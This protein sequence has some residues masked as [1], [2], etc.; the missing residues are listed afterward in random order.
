MSKLPP[1]PQGFTLEGAQEPA[2]GSLPPIPPGFTLEQAEQAPPPSAPSAPIEAG[3]GRAVGLAATGFNRMLGN[4][5]AFPFEAAA[6]FNEMTG[7]NDA[8]EAA[9]GYKANRKPILTS[10]QAQ[11]F[12]NNTFGA[13]DPQNFPER[14]IAAGGAGLGS[15]VIG[16]PALAALGAPAVAPVAA[17]AGGFSGGV[18]GQAGA[19]GGEAI[20]GP[21]GRVIGGL[22]GNIAGGAIVPSTLGGGTAT[23]RTGAALARPLTQS[24][25][26]AIVGQVLNRAAGAGRTTLA[27]EPVQGINAT[28]G[29]RTGNRGVLALE[30]MQAQS[31]PEASGRFHENLSNAQ[32]LIRNTLERLRGTGAPARPRDVAEQQIGQA[33]AA[34]A[35][36][37]HALQSGRT[38]TQASDLAR[39]RIEATRQAFRE[40]ETQLWQAVGADGE[41]A[42]VPVDPLRTRLRAYLSSQP[43]A[44]D[45]AMPEDVQAALYRLNPNEPLAELTPIRT[46]LRENAQAARAANNPRMARVYS[47]LER[48]VGGYL[49]NLQFDDA[50]VQSA[51]Q[52]A[53]DFSRHRA[54]LFN[55]QDE[56]R[57]TLAVDKFGGQRTSSAE[58]LG[59]FVQP[60][61]GGRDSLRQLMALDD[62]PEM[63]SL[64]ADHFV[65]SLPQGVAPARAW[66]SRFDPALSEM[67]Q[68][69]AQLQNVVGRRAA[70]EALRETPLAMFAGASPEKAIQRLIGSPD[71]VRSAAALRTQLSRTPD[72]WRGVQSSYADEI[73]RRVGSLVEQD[74]TGNPTILPSKIAAF[75]RDNTPLSREL[76][77]HDGAATL[78][79]I[80]DAMQMVTRTSRGGFPGGSDTFSKLSGSRFVDRI[81]EAAMNERAPAVAGTAGF[82]T[83][84]AIAGPFIGGPIGGAI[85]YG[86]GAAARAAY[87]QARQ[88]IDTLL[89]DALL[90]PEL[91]RALMRRA[92]TQSL[93]ILPRGVRPYLAQYAIGSGA[94]AAATGLGRGEAQERK[95]P[96]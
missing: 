25:R 54:Q 53:R 9:T 34:A 58:T 50:N 44:Y 20:A 29:Q 5:A 56:V 61:P 27:D 65:A 4:A 68:L 46:M 8:Y 74:A 67:P 88:Q 93:E 40:Q 12:I 62:T 47:G 30:K 75:V 90:N 2:Q 60:G 15:A 16:G 39:Q 76:L 38:P 87:S 80:A 37:L 71:A 91:G 64:I 48:E 89:S 23:T 22:I 78:R 1:I 95:K 72:A 70:A 21:N 96:N 92:S 41:G 81:V 3:P 19:E 7:I 86:G 11:G 18:L 55:Q 28:L 69:R 94:G 45:N 13:T 79:T 43:K 51:Y 82:G 73:L 17:A 31:S 57:G 63:R 35:S 32:T 10:E 52:A 26:E 33:D 42:M 14:M 84:S 59:N 36:E 49:D 24:G 85:G 66:L 83:G 77:G 6:G